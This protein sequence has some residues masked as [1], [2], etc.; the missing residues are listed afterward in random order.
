MPIPKNQVMIALME[1]ARRKQKVFESISTKDE[2][3]DDDTKTVDTYDNDYDTDDVN[4]QHVL[5]GIEAIHSYAGTYVVRDNEGLAVFAQ[6]PYD[7][8]MRKVPSYLKPPPMVRYGQKVQI[9]DMVENDVYKLARGEGYLVADNSQLV[10]S[11]CIYT[12]HVHECI[13]FILNLVRM[14]TI[15]PFATVFVLNLTFI[16]L[17]AVSVFVL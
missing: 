9:A 8:T 3:N 13:Q 7:L 14:Y 5:D 16:C 17:F 4:I 2:D 15:L 11:K 1:A 12:V 6:N 10:K